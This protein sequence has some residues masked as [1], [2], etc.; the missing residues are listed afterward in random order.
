MPCS[1]DPAPTAYDAVVIGSAIYSRRWDKAARRYLKLHADELAN[2][3]P[4]CFIAARA[5]RERSRSRAPLH[6][7]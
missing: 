6:Q 4:G 2:R 1:A 3:R 5:V 7:A